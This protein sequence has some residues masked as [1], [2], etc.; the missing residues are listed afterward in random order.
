ML[1]VCCIATGY[2]MM[3]LDQ[4]PYGFGILGLTLGPMVLMLGFIIQFFAIMYKQKHK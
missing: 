1:G 2:V 3:S 4:A